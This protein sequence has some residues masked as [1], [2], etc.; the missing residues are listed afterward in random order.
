M[1][2]VKIGIRDKVG[3]KTID[4]IAW[5]LHP[6][7]KFINYVAITPLTLRIMEG[8]GL[9]FNVGL[10]TMTD[11]AEGFGEGCTTKLST[12]WGR[13]VNLVLS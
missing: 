5:I 10:W 2:W 12:L 3:E 7:C 1:L 6:E 4:I 13:K 9:G 11:F 8:F